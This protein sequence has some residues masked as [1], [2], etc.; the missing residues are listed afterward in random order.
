MH[1]EETDLVGHSRRYLSS[2]PHA[3]QR[4]LRRQHEQVL[5]GASHDVEERVEIEQV[6]RIEE[7]KSAA[8]LLQLQLEEVSPGSRSAFVVAQEDVVPLCR[9]KP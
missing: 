1:D 8:M 6:V 7:H 4:L 3:P 9:P 2:T 5:R